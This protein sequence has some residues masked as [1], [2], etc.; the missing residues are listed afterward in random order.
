MLRR[1]AF[2]IAIAASVGWVV[3][4]FLSMWFMLDWCRLEA[5]PSVY[6]H[7]RAANSFPFLAAAGWMLNMAALWAAGAFAMW[8]IVGLW[9][10][11]VGKS[12]AEPADA[13]ESRS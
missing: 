3:P 12:Q 13:G 7:E 9:F 10:A 2:V 1:L 5:S 8:L 11:A 4:L 6:G